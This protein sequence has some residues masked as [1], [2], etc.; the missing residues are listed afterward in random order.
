MIRGHLLREVVPGS[1]FIRLPEARRRCHCTP[2]KR[3]TTSSTNTATTCSPSSGPRT[4]TSGG[5]RARARCPVLPGPGAILPGPPAVQARAKRGASCRIDVKPRRGDGASAPAATR[6]YLHQSEA[7]DELLSPTPRPVVVTTGT[8][9][10]KTEAFLLPVIQNAFEDAVR[11]KKQRPDG[12]PRLPDER[13]GE[14]PEAAHRGVPRR[15]PVSPGRSASSKYDR[16]TSQ[17]KRDE[18]RANPPHILLTNYMM[19]EY[20]LVRPADREDIFANHRCRFLVLDEVHTY[21]GTLGSNIALLVRRLKRP[22]RPRPAGLEADASAPRSG[23]N[24]IPQLVAGGHVGHDQERSP[25]K[26]CPREERSRLRDEAVQSSSARWPASK[27]A[28]I[29]VLGEELQDVPIPRRGGYPAQA[30]VIDV[31]NLDVS[32]AEA[33]RQGTLPPGRAAGNHGAL[34]GA[35]RSLPAAV[36]PEPLAHPPADVDLRHR[37]TTAKRGPRAERHPRE[38][39]DSRSRGRA[40]ARC[41]H[42]PMELPARCALR[43]HRFIRGGWQFHRCV[44]PGCGGCSPRARSNARPATTDR[45]ALPV[46]ELRCRLPAVCRRPGCRAAGAD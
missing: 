41:A 16:S 25:R 19:L 1:H 14:R 31:A 6:A 12:H 5:A 18:M 7:I 35:A 34:T 29:R 15:T 22:S 38:R 26:A 9:S 17:A 45:A 46:P 24:G 2:S 13:P 44:N 3:S 42:C 8:G 11:F 33:V 43:V 40:G 30:R 4:R 10:G 27:R 23:R 37:R 39:A 21:R 28:T 36:G 20:L 32:D